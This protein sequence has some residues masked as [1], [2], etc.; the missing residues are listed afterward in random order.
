MDMTLPEV[1]EKALAAPA[2]DAVAEI[3]KVVR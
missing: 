2:A 3:L 1:D